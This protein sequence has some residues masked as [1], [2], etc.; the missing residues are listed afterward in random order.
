MS[1][2]NKRSITSFSN[3]NPARIAE[4]AAILLRVR[5]SAILST[6]DFSLVQFNWYG[7]RFSEPRCSPLTPDIVLALIQQPLVKY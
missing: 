4:A 1:L 2:L 3:T 7:Q 5:P 6:E